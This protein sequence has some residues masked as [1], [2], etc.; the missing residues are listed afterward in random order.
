MSMT[1]ADRRTYDI[2]RC[3]P[4][5]TIEDMHTLRLV[6]WEMYGVEVYP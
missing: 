3:N 5:L 2:L 1:N 6:M 4:F